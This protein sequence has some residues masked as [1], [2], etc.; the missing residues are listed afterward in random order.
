LN[1]ITKKIQEKAIDES[2][3]GSSVELPKIEFSGADDAASLRQKID[4]LLA[5]GRL[6]K[7]KK[8]TNYEISLDDEPISKIPI[9]EAWIGD[10]A[11]AVLADQ[12]IFEK[13]KK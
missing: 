6:S 11:K 5:I 7:A 13:I 4:Q 8:G 10:F 12:V 1:E 9:T 2:L 3:K